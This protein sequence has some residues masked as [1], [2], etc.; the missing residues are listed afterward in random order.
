[1][2]SVG[3]KLD[4]NQ[5]I[6]QVYDEAGNRLRVDAVVS[7]SIGSVEIIDGD[8]DSL[9]VNPDG[10]INVAIAGPIAIEIDAAD[11]DN[12]AISDGTHTLDVNSDGSINVDLVDNNVIAQIADGTNPANKLAIDAAGTVTTKIQD[13]SGNS[14]SSVGGALNV[15]LTTA[16]LDIRD[17]DFATD[18]V[19][20]TGSSV[21]V[22]NFPT[23]SAKESKQ[24]VGNTSLASIDGKLNSLGQKNMAGSMPVVL[25]SDQPALDVSLD[26]FTATPD[27]VQLVG[28]INGLST[29]TKYGFV[30]NIRNQIL[31]AHDRIQNITYADFGTKDQR[32]TQID[33]T[34]TTFIGFIARKTI[35]YTLVGT[36]YRRDS[37]SWV[38]I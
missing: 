1:M 17:L 33:Y 38:I 19:D 11:G 10:S 7:A 3:T 15:N 12:I 20:V 6:K 4:S 32:I 30:N 37:I 22:S 13:S 2:S 8:G 21:A 24:D 27:S 29:G 14:L 25:A 35:A 31:A 34:S 28:S 16:D 36:R 18:S 23:D 9:N 5:V 26:A